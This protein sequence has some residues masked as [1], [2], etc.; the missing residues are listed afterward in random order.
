MNIWAEGIDMEKIRN[1]KP[2]DKP[3]LGIKEE[4]QDTTANGRRLKKE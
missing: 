3:L 4:L 2:E 1:N